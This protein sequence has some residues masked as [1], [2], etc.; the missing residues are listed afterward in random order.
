M[1]PAQQAQVAMDAFAALPHPAGGTL[2]LRLKV[3]I[4]T[5]PA[6]RFLVGDPQIQLLDVL[7]GATIDRMAAAEHL[8]QATEI[9][10]DQAT[11]VALGDQDVAA[12]R[13]DPA[14][15]ARF[16]V[17]GTID[18]RRPMTDDTHPRWS[19]VD[20][21]SSEQLR[22]WL[23]PTVYNRLVAG[24][25]ELLTELRPVVACF[26]R[27]GGLDYDTDPDAPTKLNDYI[28]WVQQVV[29]AYEGVVLQLS[30]GDKGSYLYA[31]WGAPIS[32]EDD[33]QRA[34]RAA[35][36]LRI[37]PPA[38]SFIGSVQI[39]LSRGEMR[40]GAYGSTTRRCYGALGDEVNL[41][42]RLMQVAPPG[43][44][45]A[46]GRVQA[47]CAD[48][49]VWETLPP[50]HVKG[51]Q[52]LVPAFLLHEARQ[53]TIR[54]HEP[55]Y[56]APLIGR[57]TELA[58]IAT[59]LQRAAV[60]AGQIIGVVGEAGLGKSRLV[61]E[62]VRMAQSSEWIIYGGAA[63]SF[64]TSSAYLAWQ[65]I[66]QAWFGLP[67]DEAEPVGHI[68]CE[69][70]RL[71]PDATERLPLLEAVLGL[72]LPPS[73]LTDSMDEKLRKESREALLVE[74][75]QARA[76]QRPVLLVLEDC[77][78]LDPLSQDLLEAIGRATMQL[79][80]V[81]VLAYRIADL[82]R[83]PLPRVAAL[84][85]FTALPLASLA[86][87]QAAA[88]LTLR[89]AAARPGDKL[90]PVLIERLVER[91]QGN[92]FYL[93]EL[94]GYL[95]DQGVDL[96]DP[97]VGARVELPVSLQSL[98]LSR[99]DQLDDRAQVTL[100][101]ASV[102]GR[103][104][105]VAW[106]AIYQP[107]L[108]PADQLHSDLAELAR[109]E[110]VVLDTPDPDL[111]YLFKH[112]ITH[113]VVYGSL[114]EEV[115][116]RLHGQVAAWLEQAGSTD[117]DLLAYHYS[118]SENIAK[119]REYLR[120]AGD[121]AAAAWSNA[122]AANYYKQLLAE[123]TEADAEW[124][125]MLRALGEMQ[126]RQG[127]WDA[128]AER[129]SLALAAAQS[130]QAYAAAAHGLGVVRCKQGVYMQASAWLEAACSAFAAAGDRAGVGQ[131]Q[132]EIGR[133]YWLQGAYGQAREILE[134]SL[135]MAQDAHDKSAMAKILYHLGILAVRQGDLT[136]ARALLEESLSLY[137][138]QGSRSA[139]AS[140]LNSLGIVAME[141]SEFDIARA[142][143]EQSLVLRRE[144]GDR[145][146]LALTLGNLCLMVQNQGDWK[147]AQCLHTESMSLSQNLGDRVGIA[148]T[149]QNLGIG[150]I[151]Q[152]ELRQA[153]E[154]IAA[155]LRLC[156]ELG[157]GAPTPAALVGAAA[158]IE[159]SVVAA[160][161]LGAGMSLL[162][163]Q[164]SVLEALE[165]RAYDQAF[166]A[167]HASLG[168]AASE[169][170]LAEGQAL[171]WERAIDIAVA[172]LAL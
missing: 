147:Q 25:D 160:R 8:A 122:A 33:D 60:G 58:L 169:S 162:A 35:L 141:Q 109:L 91:A 127:D 145:W 54:L 57:Q 20:G 4:T 87:D 15:G 39:G 114:A 14:T 165:Q 171:S 110:L 31:A 138:Q 125:T 153:R 48:Y 72:H 40:T 28:C 146:G 124:S 11:I 126:E 66:W 98:I 149:L 155:C 19:V 119:R 61:A 26:L 7:A 161:V 5:G 105:R 116:V 42:A 43:Q 46:S 82:A 117:L 144:L 159:A 23:L 13:A 81:V 132:I 120:R 53:A 75:L 128:A 170:A 133:I 63:Q 79:P 100:K 78:W 51:K 158:A 9:V 142:Q 143:L 30:L 83:P 45:L 167:I 2:A 168:L 3:A 137:Q 148:N 73:E 106:L 36:E 18:D 86:S 88:F 115:R 38:F 131:S 134:T 154:Q 107:S 123:L 103:L 157:P 34:V 77:H 12:W 89:L 52:V 104:I 111:A 68:Q 99:V 37:P 71:A 50:F 44:I 59:L 96:T 121:S 56:H 101:A 67:V 55:R 130:Q 150:A 94:L 95:I 164:G 62:V 29:A 118:R 65:P 108:A 17:L 112:I 85:N 16:A 47:A 22:P 49:F 41:A 135:R 76:H 74:L 93:E 163:A 32:H 92:P 113:E 102:L 6:Q 136:S 129:Y 70:A 84:P 21:L 10:V 80:V 24:Q 97:A 166:A 27:F 90:A 69:L 140:V 139:C 172:A 1:T 151:E 64:G 156:R 152:G